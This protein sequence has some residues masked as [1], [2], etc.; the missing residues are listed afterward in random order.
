M[1]DSEPVEVVDEPVRGPV[2]SS[3]VTLEVPLPVVEDDVAEEVVLEADC[4]LGTDEPV[5]ASVLPV[6]WADDVVEGWIG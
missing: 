5:T 4:V 6:V 1:V 2:G 3:E